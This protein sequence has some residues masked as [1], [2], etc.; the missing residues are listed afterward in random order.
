MDPPRIVKA[1][2]GPLR[3]SLGFPMGLNLFKFALVFLAGGCGRLAFEFTT[4]P[5]IELNTAALEFE[6]TISG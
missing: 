3:G 1:H 6:P 5:V 2:D 4:T